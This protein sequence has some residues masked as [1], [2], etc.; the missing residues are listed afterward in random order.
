MGKEGPPNGNN[1]KEWSSCWV[2]VRS[3]NTPIGH[4][5]CRI[6]TMYGNVFWMFGVN[7]LGATTHFRLRALHLF[8]FLRQQQ[9][10]R[11]ENV[12][13][14]ILTTSHSAVKLSLLKILSMK[15]TNTVNDKG[16]PWRS[17]ILSDNTL[18]YCQECRHSCNW[19][20]I[21]TWCPITRKYTHLVPLSLTLSG[22]WRNKPNMS[23]Y[24]TA[25]NSKWLQDIYLHKRI[26]FTQKLCNTTV[27]HL[28]NTWK[29]S[30]K[31]I[32]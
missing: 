7:K 11:F 30:N 17:P 3:T 16:R 26:L 1:T 22:L 10:F 21:R 6:Q 28:H 19:V 4:G 12:L 5:W 23:T 25:A 29:L 13:T 8:F 14:L 20:Y 9:S 24:V 27:T 2:S 18:T 32:N 15:I 31:A